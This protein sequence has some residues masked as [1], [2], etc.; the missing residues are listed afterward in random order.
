MTSGLL[1]SVIVFNFFLGLM[2]EETF[3]KAK[4]AKISEAKNTLRAK[5][6]GTSSDESTCNIERRTRHGP[7][8][9]A[10]R[11][12]DRGLDNCSRSQIAVSQKPSLCNDTSYS[13][14]S[15]GLIC[16]TMRLPLLPTRSP[17]VP[18]SATSY[19]TLGSV[20]TSLKSNSCSYPSGLLT[21]STDPSFK[22]S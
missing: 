16:S 6:L 21:S 13:S 7:S 17:I 5:S 2:K 4:V 20:C 18:P 22:N 11:S 9:M 14:S 10:K 3:Q 12:V 1:F 15:S 19:T 8:N